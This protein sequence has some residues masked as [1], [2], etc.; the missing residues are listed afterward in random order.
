MAEARDA[1]LWKIEDV[2]EDAECRAGFT[3]ASRRPVPGKYDGVSNAELKKQLIAR[4]LASGGN[5]VARQNIVA[6]KCCTM[7]L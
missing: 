7:I 3:I 6:C 1:G 5:I 4:G 2:V